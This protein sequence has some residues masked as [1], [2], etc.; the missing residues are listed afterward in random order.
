MLGSHKIRGN[1]RTRVCSGSVDMS[2]NA[3]YRKVDD[4]AVLIAVK[5]AV[6]EATLTSTMSAASQVLID[7]YT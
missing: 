2:F 4:S 5:V 3:T 1:Y 6:A 7:V